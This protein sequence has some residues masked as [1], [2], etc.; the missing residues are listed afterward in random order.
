MAELKISSFDAGELSPSVFGRTDLPQYQ[1]GAASMQNMIV[2]PNG[3]ARKRPGTEYLATVSTTARLVPFQVSATESYLLEFSVDTLRVIDSSGTQQYTSD[4]ADSA[5]ADDFTAENIHTLKYTQLADAMVIVDRSMPPKLLTYSAGSSPEWELTDLPVQE[6]P[7]PPTFDVSTADERPGAVTFSDQRVVF[8]GSTAEPNVIWGSAI[9]ALQLH[10]DAVDS[11]D[12]FGV[13]SLVEQTVG[14]RD[15]LPGDYFRA[16]TDTSGVGASDKS[17]DVNFYANDT[18]DNDADPYNFE[19]LDYGFIDIQWII[20]SNLLQGGIVLIGTTAGLYAILGGS[21]NGAI[22]AASGIITARRQSVSGCSEVQGIVVNNYLVY[23]DATKRRIR[24][25]QFN[26]QADQ[27]ETPRIN[28]LAEHLFDSD[29]KEI[30]YQRAPLS[31][32]WVLLDDGSVRAFSYDSTGNLAAWSPMVFGGDSTC[33]SM[34][35]LLGEEE[36]TVAFL[37][38]N[39]T[40]DEYTIEKMKPFNTS[41]QDEMWYVDNGYRKYNATAFDSVSGLTHLEGETL[42]VWADGASHPDVTVSSGAVNLNREVNTVILGRQYRAEITTLPIPE[43]QDKNKRV[44]RL[45][46]RFIDTLGAKAGDT[47]FEEVV[48]F[49]EGNFEMGA[50]PALYTGMKEIPYQGRY[51]EDAQVTLFSDTPTP[52]HV[53]S[54]ITRLEV[55]G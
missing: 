23:V 30:H 29:I 15:Y 36:D 2:M 47:E 31:I 1:R 11:T 5:I 35:V 19:V 50:Q 7:K 51:D 43:A 55:Y 16:G 22:S 10:R 26:L 9:Q 6:P 27:F 13:W 40:Q 39:E 42:Q 20:N 38:Y 53:L 33:E 45:F 46:A 28:D 32:L 37:M 44:S 17:T 41:D 8:A 3:S 24:I 54:L 34:A 14:G 48:P 18:S 4:T 52:F 21:S 49:R 12:S 25:A